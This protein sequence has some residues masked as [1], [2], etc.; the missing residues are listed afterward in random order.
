V[1][2]LQEQ[3][4]LSRVKGHLMPN[5]GEISGYEIHVGNTI[6]SDLHKP[7][8]QLHDRYDSAISQDQQIVGTYVHGL[9]DSVAAL[10]WLFDWVE[11]KN[12]PVAD[13]QQQREQGINRIADIVEE[14]LDMEQIYK[15]LGV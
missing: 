3:K 14:Y 6:G 9:F 13:F 8:L 12:I 5:H 15:I 1:T 2:T 10:Q 7:F 4:T 11:F